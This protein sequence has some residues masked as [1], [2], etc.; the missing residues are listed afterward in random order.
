MV[1]DRCGGHRKE[2]RSDRSFGGEGGIDGTAELRRRA[3]LEF[4]DTLQDLDI[5]LSEEALSEEALKDAWR[6]DA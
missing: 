6:E 1:A 2:P 3:S 4:L 5:D